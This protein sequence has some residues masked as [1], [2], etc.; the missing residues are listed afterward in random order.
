LAEREHSVAVLGPRSTDQEFAFTQGLLA[1]GELRF[2]QVEI[3][4]G[5]AVV[6]ALKAALRLRRLTR[7]AD[8]VHAHGVRA[9]TVAVV[10]LMRFPLSRRRNR[11]PGFVITF[12]NAMLG[13]TLRRRVLRFGMSALACAADAVL[14]VSEDL[15]A[16]LR[17]AAPDVRRALVCADPPTFSR[18]G[19]SVRSELGLAVDAPMVLAVG[20]LH[21]QKGFDVLIDAAKVLQE[22]VGDAVVL[23]A[24][25]G[26]QR[27]ALTEKLLSGKGNVRLLGHRDDTADLIRAADV[28]V[29]PSRWEGWPLAAAEVLAVGRPLV[30]TRVGGLPHLVGDAAVLVPPGSASALAAAIA[31]VL[32]DPTFAAALADR[33][34]RR[35]RELP[36]ND[37]VVEQLLACYQAILPNARS[38]AERAR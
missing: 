24:G 21:P 35:A 16:D 13:A 27:S 14:A 15:A 11:R 29:M 30:A 33:A 38:V 23:I 32:V 7:H 3:A 25:E 36:V 9:A 19:E 12:H 28:V 1:D 26:P 20:R 17:A 18:D 37:D 2:R 10:A 34:N 5:L 31:S 8:I 22:T 6:G 4:S